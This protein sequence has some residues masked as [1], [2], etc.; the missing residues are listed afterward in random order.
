MSKG[1][2]IQTA[3]TAIHRRLL[4]QDPSIGWTPYLWLC[5]LIFFLVPWWFEP[6]SPP[7]LGA[8]L[9]TLVAFLGIYFHGYWHGGR[10]LIRN[11][12]GLL[13]LGMLWTPWNPSAMVFFIYA[14]GFTGAVGP[15][16]LGTQTLSAIF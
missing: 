8:I 5:Y 13:M 1:G 6:P 16:R 15:P 9:L 2:R 11:M 14:A 12:I 4:P 3:L 7:I 10:A